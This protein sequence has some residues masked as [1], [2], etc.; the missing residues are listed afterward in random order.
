MYIFSTSV[1]H[2]NEEVDDILSDFKDK[3]A[4]LEPHAD[5]IEENHIS[6]ILTFEVEPTKEF[7]IFNRISNIFEEYDLRGECWTLTDSNGFVV[8]TEE[9]AD[10]I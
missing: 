8:A 3:Y 9:H 6:G 2:Y 5:V 7:S 10:L 4:G 1:S